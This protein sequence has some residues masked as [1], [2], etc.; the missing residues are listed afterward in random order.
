M[1][2]LKDPNETRQPCYK[3]TIA[4]LGAKTFSSRASGLRNAA[5]ASERWG[6]TLLIPGGRGIR[7]SPSGPSLCNSGISRLANGI[8]RIASL[9][10][11]F[12]QWLRA[13]CPTV[14]SDRVTGSSPPNW[15]A[16]FLR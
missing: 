15:P 2:P 16:A 8:R 4:A 3:V 11:A 7:L 12:L 1:H 5:I 10:R 6:H 14:A 9:M 13:E